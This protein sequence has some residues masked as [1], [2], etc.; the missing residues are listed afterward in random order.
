MDQLEDT[1]GVACFVA[2]QRPD[3]VPDRPGAHLGNL[4]QRLL[5]PVLTEQDMPRIEQPADAPFD[6]VADRADGGEVAAGGVVE[7]PFLVPLAGEDRAGVAAR[8]SAM[9]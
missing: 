1:D 6:L 3:E 9:A 8:A 7:L 5:D 2:L 4:G